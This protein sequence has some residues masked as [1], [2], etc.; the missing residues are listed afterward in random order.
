M[1]AGRCWWPHSGYFDVGCVSI[2]VTQ[3][4]SFE[5][6]RAMNNEPLPTFSIDNADIAL[7]AVHL[8]MTVLERDI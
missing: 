8:Q 6:T 2:S 3:S 7:G 1:G 5:I 4:M